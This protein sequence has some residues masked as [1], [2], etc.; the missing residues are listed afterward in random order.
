MKEPSNKRAIET[1]DST[2]PNSV[3]IK[4]F[5]QDKVLVFFV[6][7][8]LEVSA[9]III[10]FWKTQVKKQTESLE[11]KI[12]NM[13]KQKK[14]IDVC[15]VKICQTANADRVLLGRFHNGSV[16]EDGEHDLS[17]S[18]TNEYCEKGFSFV[19]NKLKNIPAIKLKNEIAKL[20]H[21]KYLFVNLDSAQLACKEYMLSKN[22]K[23]VIEL[24]ITKNNKDG[25]N[26]GIIGIISIQFQNENRINSVFNLSKNKEKLQKIESQRLIIENILNAHLDRKKIFGVF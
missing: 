12:E 5:F 24:A 9:I 4:E 22:L 18:A 23:Q 16:Y 19:S 21:S 3:E 26:R 17:F 11:A 20:K 1:N 10:F 13:D 25:A 15:L 7:N 8:I 14:D 2:S 6:E